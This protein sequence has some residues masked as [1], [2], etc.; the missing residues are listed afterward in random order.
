[1]KNNEYII[2]E[3]LKGIRLDKCIVALDNEISRATVQ[4]LIDEKNILVNDKNE[5]ASY[6][7]NIRR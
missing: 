2:D 7:V 5:K 4:R 1:M 6:K 3:S